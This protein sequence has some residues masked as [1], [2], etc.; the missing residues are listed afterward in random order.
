MS[1]PGEKSGTEKEKEKNTKDELKMI[2]PQFCCV[3]CQ[4][5]DL[6]K[7]PSLSAEIPLCFLSSLRSPVCY[8]LPHREALCAGGSTAHG[9]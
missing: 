7:T 9:L 3:T 5:I 2:Y 1:C 8:F 4:K 6:G